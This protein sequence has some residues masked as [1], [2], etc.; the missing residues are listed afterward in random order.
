MRCTLYFSVLFLSL[1]LS[2]QMTPNAPVQDFRFPRFGDN[3][4]TQWVLQGEQGVYDSDAQIRVE[5]MALRV[6]SGD[7]RMALEL[8]LDS[9]E[10]TL[11]LKENRAFSEEAI[12]IVGANFKITGLGWEW[13]GETKEIVVKAKT[14]VQFTQ[15]IA[16][17]FTEVSADV[18]DKTEIRSERLMLRTTED[19]YHFE[20]TGQVEALSQEMDLRSERLIAVADPPEGRK[21]SG[22]APTAPTELDSLRRIFAEESVT[23]VQSGKTVQADEAEFFPREE[24]AILS[25]NATVS[26]PGA[27]FSGQSLRSRS[28]EIVLSGAEG[29]GRAQLILMET[30]GLGLQGTSELSAETIV[31]SDTIRMRELPGENRFL[32]QGSVEVMSGALQMRAE[33]MTIVSIPESTAESTTDGA[34]LRVGDVQSI[35][36][37]GKVEIEQGGQFATGERVTFYPNEQRAELTG[38]PRVTNGVAVITGQRMELKPRRAIVRGESS[39]PVTVRLPELPDLGYDLAVVESEELP[40]ASEETELVETVVTSLV[41]RMVE[42]NDH[43]LFRFTDDVQVEA[44]NLKATTERLDVIAQDA[45]DNN[46]V[47]SSGNRAL[48]LDRIEAHESVEIIQAGRIST[49]DRAFIL[50]R[51]GKVVL[52]GEAVVDDERGRVSGHRMTLLQGQRKAVVEGG[53]SGDGRARITLPALPN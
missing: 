7:E 4:Y 30:G 48:Q 52:E 41:L 13:S 35:S 49:A 8:S 25:G 47:T 15:G 3:G 46:E 1:S 11:R 44:T 33:K 40:S 17:A 37:E 10:A 42:E 34:E 2:A 9:P 16:S 43:T 29:Q 24:R 50:P 20:F 22:G 36:A 18:G 51:S 19:A 6:Y 38:E 45:R 32:F 23:I 27:Y 5:G 21:A 28:G 12:K 39:D 53:G 14:K 31:L 26:T